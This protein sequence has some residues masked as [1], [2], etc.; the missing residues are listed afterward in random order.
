MA[1]SDED[2]EK[3]GYLIQDF[4]IFRL[5]DTMLQDIPFHYHDFHKIIFFLKG[6]A[7]YTIEGKTYPLQPRDIIFVSAGEIHRPL[8]APG[9]PYERIVI[10]ISPAFLLRCSHDIEH[11]DTCFTIARKGSSVMHAEPGKTHD[12]LYH[13]EQLDKTAHDNGFANKLYAE[14]QFLEFMI[15]L[16]R[17]LLDHE[18]DANHSAAYD[19]KIMPLLAYINQHLADDLS[20]DFLAG[21]FYMSKF[22]MMRKFKKETGYTIHQ[23][24]TNKRLLQARNLLASSLPLTKICFDC[25]F[26][27]YSSFSRSFKELFHQTP[28]DYRTN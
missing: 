22:H 11:L 26:K 12:L 17:A 7:D 21:R 6:Q 3:K 8:P 25:G 16:N 19:K 13:M 23:Y 15:L 18:I 1:I 14:L 28:T 9:R 20:V 4:R 5:H 10:Y 27:D 2:Y 24:I